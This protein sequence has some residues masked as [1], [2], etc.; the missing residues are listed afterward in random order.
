[1]ERKTVLNWT[2][3]Q[4]NMLSLQTQDIDHVRLQERW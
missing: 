4:Q 1:M 3:K 2:M